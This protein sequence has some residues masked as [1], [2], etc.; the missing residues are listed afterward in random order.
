MLLYR[1]GGVGETSS[2]FNN[3]KMYMYYTVQL[4]FSTDKTLTWRIHQYARVRV[5]MEGGPRSRPAPLPTPDTPQ[6]QSDSCQTK[7]INEEYRTGRLCTF[8]CLWY[9]QCL[10]V[11]GSCGLDTLHG[12]K[13]RNKY[14]PEKE[15]RDLSPNFHIHVSVSDL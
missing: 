2:L 14:S 9:L 6:Q 4:I 12:K 3:T 7:S 15:L 13:I 10:G 8:L 11:A 5:C 1:T